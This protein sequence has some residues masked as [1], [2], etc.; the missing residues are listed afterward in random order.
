MKRFTA[1][2][3]L[4]ALCV[5]GAAQAC[6]EDFGGRMSFSL[7]GWDFGLS[8][9][10]VGRL[11]FGGIGL[12]MDLNGAD[13]EPGETGDWAWAFGLKSGF[14]SAESD[15]PFAPGDFRIWQTALNAHAMNGRWA[16]SFGVPYRPPAAP[17]A[18]FPYDGPVHTIRTLCE[19]FRDREF[20]TVL[21]ADVWIWT[22]G[23]MLL[24]AINMLAKQFGAK[25]EMASRL[26]ALEMLGLAAGGLLSVRLS[27]QRHWIHFLGGAMVLAG[28]T[29]A[30]MKGLEFMPAQHLWSLGYALQI[31]TGV[32]IGLVLIPCESFLQIR[33]PDDRKGDMLAAANFLVFA[34]IT[35][36]SLLMGVMLERFGAVNSIAALGV[37]SWPIGIWLLLYRHEETGGERN[38]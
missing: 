28:I 30:G 32:F 5:G 2:V 29:A 10:S 27:R 37:V 20:R 16:V 24:Q 25:M 31:L 38:D 23:A 36:G 15:L 21:L 19:I 13:Y 17:H 18:K 12:R 26:N 33:P 22:F 7:H 8:E 9:A 1:L 6:S 11:R 14:H 4:T 34:G 35:G 3:L